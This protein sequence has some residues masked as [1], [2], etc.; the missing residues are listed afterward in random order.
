[1]TSLALSLIA[2]LQL[3]ALSASAAD[4]SETKHE[5]IAADKG[6]LVC[7]NADGTKK[8]AK[9]GFGGVHRI[10]QLADGHLLTQTNFQHLVELDADQNFVWEYDSSKAN[11]NAGKKVEVH[12]FQRL[13]N[14]NTMIVENGIGRIIEVDKDGKI[15]HE[16]KY[17]VSQTNAHRDVR[18][19]RKLDNGHYLLCHEGEGRVTEYD[20]E[21]EIVWDY[22]VPLFD[23]EPKGGHGPEAWGNQVFNALRLK[24]G[25]T[26]IA[27]GNGHSVI[28]VN[29]DKEVV[30][31]LHQND[32][33]DI[34]LAWTTTLE[35]LDNGNIILGNC[36]AGK[37]NP[38]LIEVTREKKVVWTFHDFDLL[39]DST[40]A[41]ATVGGE[42]VL[43]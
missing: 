37:D 29:P 2:G 21:G 13:D 16:Q 3:F 38:Q 39:G 41:S 7:F 1:V 30:W 6:K 12:A 31:K 43:R 22:G 9:Q 33:E 27:T 14:G 36:H 24:N 10:Q 17:Q 35:V 18:Q 26:L 23:K 15:V 42:D 20:K 32:L 11:G 34:T 5:V 19:G 25:N 40:A 8:W 4:V 28:E